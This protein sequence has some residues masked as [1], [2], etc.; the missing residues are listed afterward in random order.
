MDQGSATKKLLNNS[1]AEI[2]GGFFMYFY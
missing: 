2:H 1:K